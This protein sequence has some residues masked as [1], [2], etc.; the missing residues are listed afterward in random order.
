MLGE[1]MGRSYLQ[2]SGTPQYVVRYLRGFAEAEGSLDDA[3]VFPEQA[4][5]WPVY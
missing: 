2:H 3:P 5:S 1:Y 4:S